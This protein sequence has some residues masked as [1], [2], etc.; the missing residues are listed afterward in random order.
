[1]PRKG[2][3]RR[4][5]DRVAF[6]NFE[7]RFSISQGPTGV[8]RE[9]G[10]DGGE[11]VLGGELLVGAAGGPGDS[12]ADVAFVLE[13]IS[14]LLDGGTLDVVGEGGLART[15]GGAGEDVAASVGEA[16]SG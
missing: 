1:L 4:K 7:F 6:L 15:W 8:V 16:A 11:E 3:K 13:P 5:K 12:E 14:D 9:D 2:T 10:L